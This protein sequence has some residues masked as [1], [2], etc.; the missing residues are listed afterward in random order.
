[1]SDTASGPASGAPALAVAARRGRAGVTVATP[2]RPGNPALRM[3][4]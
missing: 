3:M 4:R 1:M 2:V